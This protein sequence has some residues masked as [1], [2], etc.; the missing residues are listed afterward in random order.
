MRLGLDSLPKVFSYPPSP[1]PSPPLGGEGIKGKN[2]WQRRS[3]LGPQ[4]LPSRVALLGTEMVARLAWR[5]KRQDNYKL[6]KKKLYT[7]QVRHIPWFSGLSRP[8]S[9]VWRRGIRSL[10]GPFVPVSAITL[11]SVFCGMP[12]RPIK[13]CS[14][15]LRPS[16]SRSNLR[17]SYP[18]SYQRKN[19]AGI[20]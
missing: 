14:A 1:Y 11:N 20:S 3:F 9:Q 4:F 7:S 12:F 18:L 2:F 13:N 10:W 16:L 17:D 6:S 5:R 15:V 19:I 8:G